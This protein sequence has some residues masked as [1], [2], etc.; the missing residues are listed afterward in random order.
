MRRIRRVRA[1]LLALASLTL[2]IAPLPATT[3][4]ADT[5]TACPIGWGSFAKTHSTDT[6][7]PLTNLS[8]ARHNCFD[9]VVIDVLGADRGSLGYSVRYV[10]R[11][12]Q[13][14]SGLPIPVSGGAIIAI[15]VHAPAYDIS[16]GKPTYSAKPDDTLPGVNLKDYRTF[17]DAKFGGS[18]EGYT[19]FGLGLRTRLPFR[20]QTLDGHIVV[21]VAHSWTGDWRATR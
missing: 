3:A 1:T 13:D 6:T 5:T 17:R 15:M 7:A 19:Q 8:T 10:D 11:F 4:L 2:G 18:F 20:V 9:R 14:G 21:D 12:F 16:T